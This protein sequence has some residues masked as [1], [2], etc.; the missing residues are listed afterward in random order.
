[1]MIQ[2]RRYITAFKF[3]MLLMI[4]VVGDSGIWYRWWVREVD[5]NGVGGVGYGG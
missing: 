1:M 2:A 3:L 4:A 5:G